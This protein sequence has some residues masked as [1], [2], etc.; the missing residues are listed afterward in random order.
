M[1][2]YLG[3]K[4]TEPIDDLDTFPAPEGIGSVTMT[5]DEVTSVCPI[6]GQPDYYTVTIEYEPDRLCIESKSLKLYLW[7]FRDQ[8][9]F[10]ESMAVEIRKKVEAVVQ[11]RYVTVSVLQKPRGGIAIEAVSSTE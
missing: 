11:P 6:T 3:K 9:G 8:P 10:C 5:S 2:K 1:A 4:T 7:H